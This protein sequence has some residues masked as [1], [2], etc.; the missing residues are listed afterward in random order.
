MCTPLLDE[1]FPSEFPPYPRFLL[2]F[3]ASCF[4]DCMASPNTA[5]SEI[6]CRRKGLKDAEATETRVFDSLA[7]FAL[8]ARR[9]W[10]VACQVGLMQKLI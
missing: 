2:R 10:G 8:K 1:R 3:R 6:S 9:V 4:D 7:K 5:R